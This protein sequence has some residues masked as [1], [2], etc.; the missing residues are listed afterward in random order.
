MILADANVL[1][2]AAND[3]DTHHDAAVHLLRYVIGDVVV[4][5]TIVAES[6]YL[7][8]KYRGV[9]AEAALLASIGAG[10]LRLEAMTPEDFVRMADLVRQYATLNIGAADASIVAVAERLG[11][12]EIATFDRRHFTVVRPSHVETFTLLP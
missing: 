5:P 3:R 11:I 6:C 10:D 9:E 1:V 4:V 8:N 7:I 12:T 2:A